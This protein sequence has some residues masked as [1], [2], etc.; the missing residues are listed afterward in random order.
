MADDGKLVPFS[1]GAVV[2][3]PTGTTA[4]Q[5]PRPCT[6]CPL[7]LRPFDFS[8][9]A[10]AAQPPPVPVPAIKDAEQTFGPRQPSPTYFRTLPAA[11]GER[12]PTPPSTPLVGEPRDIE[13]TEDAFD[14]GYYNMHFQ[15]VSLIGRGSFGSVHL[16]RH[17]VGSEVV[18]IFAVKKI[19]VGDDAKYLHKVLAEVKTM[20][21]VGQHPNVVQYHHAWLD[22]AKTS[23]YGPSVRCLFILME[24]AAFGSL[25]SIMEKHQ[26]EL[27]D[28]AVWFFFLS[29]LRGLDHLHQRGVLHRDIK[30][31]NV[32]LAGDQAQ[33]DRPRTTAPPRPVLA[34]F[35]TSADI[36]DHL[37]PEAVDE[38]LRGRTGA[39]G[40]ED[41]M[42]PELLEK[43]EASASTAE[44][45]GFHTVAS[46]LYATGVLLHRLAFATLPGGKKLVH[47]PR[48][49]HAL[50]DALL[51]RDP[52]HRPSSAEA[53]LSVPEVIEKWKRVAKMT[54]ADLFGDR[55][56]STRH[57]YQIA[58]APTT[59]PKEQSV[60]A[61]PAAPMPTPPAAAKSAAD[62]N[63]LVTVFALG[64]VV[65]L[66]AARS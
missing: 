26:E 33:S 38:L 31:D 13:A 35:G 56:R 21:R 1:S 22:V 32:L 3:S 36:P 12:S 66:L 63:A 52:A 17:V 2:P 37:A 10:A 62:T 16:C 58:V 34:D 49:M 4:R 19:P 20:E 9:Q 50:I 46:D 28:D 27:S 30:A 55:A 8:P 41:Y 47:R 39:T 5:R 64:L 53:I 45:H 24:Y 23:D 11:G 43:F 42:A 14:T 18:G 59:G 61:P 15:E 60:A 44:Y 65:G 40:T 25:E 51:Q 7:C 6:T 54:A 57:L 29:V 48:E